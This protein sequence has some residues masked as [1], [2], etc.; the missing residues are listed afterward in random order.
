MVCGSRDN[1]YGDFCT[2]LKTADKNDCPILLVDSEAQVNANDSPWQHLKKRDKWDKPNGA[3]D[4]QAH[5]MVQCMEAWFMAD[6]DCVKKYFGQ[7]FNENLLPKQPKIETIPKVD[8]LDKLK[9]ATRNSKNKGK[10]SKGEYSFELLA[11]I[12][13]AKVRK[14]SPHAKRLLDTLAKPNH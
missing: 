13:P 4:G 1:A 5:L 14:A 2:A 10:Y 11:L 12:D 6:K 3:G 7:G 8:L 9:E